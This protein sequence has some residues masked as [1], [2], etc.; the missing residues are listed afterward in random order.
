M[1]DVSL[2]RL[3]TGG[4]LVIFFLVDWSNLLIF[5]DFQLLLLVLSSR[6]LSIHSSE[7]LLPKPPKIKKMDGQRLA[8][9]RGF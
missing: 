7:P 2:P 3:I 8:Q 5:I 4:Y 6:L 9:N 1:M